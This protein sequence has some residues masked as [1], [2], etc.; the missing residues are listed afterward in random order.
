MV[1]SS[2]AAETA[3][4]WHSKVGNGGTSMLLLCVV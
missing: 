1:I 3:R 2:S 4:T